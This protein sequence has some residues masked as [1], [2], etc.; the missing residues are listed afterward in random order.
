M[1]HGF[2]CIILVA[3]L[4]FLMFLFFGCDISSNDTKA[5]QTASPLPTEVSTP[6]VTQTFAPTFVDGIE[7]GSVFTCGVYEQDSYSSNG[8]EPIEWI[9][10]DIKDEKLLLIS[11][12]GLETMPYNT[13]G[14]TNVTWET[15]SLRK[16]L[17]VDFF[18]NAFTISE[19]EKIVATHVAAEGNL[20]YP[21]EGGNDTYDK[22]FLLSISE[23]VQYF[24]RSAD[25][26]CKLTVCCIDNGAP[27]L[28]SRLCTWW[29]RTPGGMMNCAA[30]VDRSGELV[31]SGQTVSNDETVVRPVIWFNLGDGIETPSSIWTPPA[32]PLPTPTPIPT[33]F[34]EPTAMP[35]Y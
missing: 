30:V 12:Y 29:L 8:K 16:W 33:P 10:L 28:S 17:N 31:Y 1:K 7:I 24:P 26:K 14:R 35:D 13:N 27:M 9:V 25:S 32:T 19:K 23:L 2:K 22:V 34:R 4:C 11:K 5:E 6:V 18:N 21:V 15:S 3:F 20:L